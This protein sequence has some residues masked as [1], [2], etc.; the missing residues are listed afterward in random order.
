[1]PLNSSLLKNF[2][3]SK[4]VGSVNNTLNIV[5]KTIPIYKQVSPIIKNVKSVFDTSKSIKKASIDASQKERA[6]FARPVT[7]FKKNTP[8]NDRGKFNLDTLT[9]F[10]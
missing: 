1:M 10:Q 6:S 5:N 4:I 2:S 3:I 8:N 9:F 7:I